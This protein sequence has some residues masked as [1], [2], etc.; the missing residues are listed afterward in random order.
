MDPIT[1]AYLEDLN[2]NLLDKDTEEV[3][4]EWKKKFL[5]QFLHRKEASLF[6]SQA[7][8]LK[9]GNHRLSLNTHSL[10]NMFFLFKFTKFDERKS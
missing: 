6:S 2:C 10:E 9:H 7:V 4:E 8:C 1:K 3:A 5:G